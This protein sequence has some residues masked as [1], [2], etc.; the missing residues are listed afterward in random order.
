MWAEAVL[1]VV[2]AWGLRRACVAPAPRELHCWGS[3][4][5]DAK[6]ALGSK[7]CSTGPILRWGGGGRAAA[8]PTHWYI[9]R[10]AAGFTVLNDAVVLLLFLAL[11]SGLFAASLALLGPVFGFIG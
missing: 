9:S 2:L 1:S 8:G 4:L 11:R 6:A 7:C 3:S 10:H 5:D